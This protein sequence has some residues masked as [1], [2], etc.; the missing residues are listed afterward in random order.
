MAFDDRA[1]LQHQVLRILNGFL[2]CGCGLLRLG[3]VAEQMN[4]APVNVSLLRE[5]ST[6]LETSLIPPLRHLFKSV[7]TG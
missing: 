2:T 7:K 6:P 1:V 5:G 3:I 4:I